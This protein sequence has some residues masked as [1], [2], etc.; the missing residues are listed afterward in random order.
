MPHFDI[1]MSLDAA[2]KTYFP[3]CCGAGG[4]MNSFVRFALPGLISVLAAPAIAGSIELDPAGG[5]GG[6]TP[7][8]TPIFALPFTFFGG[9]SP[10][11]TPCIYGAT[12]VP[13]C[14]FKNDTGIDF[15]IIQISAWPGS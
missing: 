12:I 14:E 8:P 7:L 11:Q 5:G 1:T 2:I 10:G 4:S 15:D 3:Q 13:L 6:G 9:T